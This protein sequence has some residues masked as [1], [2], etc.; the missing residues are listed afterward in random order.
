MQIVF[1]TKSVSILGGKEKVLLNLANHFASIG[2][3]VEIAS[4]DGSISP[5]IKVDNSIKF[6]T[7]PIAY[8]N[9][10]IGPVKR[11]FGLTS[12][13]KHCKKFI[14]ERSGALFI[15]TDHI[16]SI[17]VF[18]SKSVQDRMVIWEHLSFTVLKSSV[19][20]WLRKY[21]YRRAKAIVAL[22]S[23]EAFFYQSIG[24]NVSCIPN[25]IQLNNQVK[26]ASQ[27]GVVWI[28]GITFE[29]GIEDVIE[30]AK[31][32]KR[33]ERKIV[34]S[35][36]GKGNRELWLSEEILVNNLSDIVFFHGETKNIQEAYNNSAVLILTS[37][38]ECFP[39]VILE[40]FSYSLPVIAYDCP[41]G[42][43]TMVAN[44]KNGF[45]IPM[46]N[47]AK[48]SEQ[49]LSL[50][51]NKQLLR[52]LGEGALRSAEGFSPEKIYLQWKVLLNTISADCK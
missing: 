32:F 33:D 35:I 9:L 12:G 14:A 40:A 51:D 8:F 30:L 46:G 28:G 47:V 25:A 24:C 16:I 5:V 50:I 4:Y 7:L 17:L 10:D 3:T 1:V 49:V 11:L 36:F 21:V 38:H 39:T 2:H 43:A 23:T 13:W 52:Q 29:K 48:M 20:I 44:N 42:P 18:F 15:T 6:T 45:L 22:N 37:K 19:W 34:I 26:S 41:T 31:I 27:N